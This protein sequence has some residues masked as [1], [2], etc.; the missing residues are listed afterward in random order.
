M[1]IK[2]FQDGYEWL[3]NFAPCEINFNGRCF[4]SVEHAYMSAKS[5]DLE[6]KTFCSDANNSPGKVKRKS[7]KILLREDWESIKVEIM[8]QLL[9]LKFSQEP[10]RT[11]LLNTGNILIQEGNRW[12]DTFWG[13][14]LNTNVGENKLGLLIM[15]IREQLGT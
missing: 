7:K 3:S 4:A 5:N 12:G 2:E 13:V 11:L 9:E 15:Q 6:W 14:D 8:Y 10:Y 1:K